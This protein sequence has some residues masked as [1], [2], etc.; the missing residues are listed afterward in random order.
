MKSS[1]HKAL[2]SLTHKYQQKI[3]QLGRAYRREDELTE[4][5]SNLESDLRLAKQ[6]AV[7]A[8]TPA[9][10]AVVS[11][12]TSHGT[13]YNESQALTIERLEMELHTAQ[14]LL[15]LGKGR[16]IYQE[17]WLAME[18][19][20]KQAQNAAQRATIDASKWESWACAYATLACIASIT[21]GV[22]GYKYAQL[23]GLL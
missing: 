13:P 23:T 2:A 16:N 20:K 21:A 19:A 9:F 17:D 10:K 5:V 3:C 7:A 4:R 6:V 1:T 8:A 11:G 15:R 22:L 12:R 14:A 18:K